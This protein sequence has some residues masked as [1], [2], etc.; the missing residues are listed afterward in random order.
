MSRSPFAFFRRRRSS[1]DELP[2]ALPDG[3]RVYAVGDIHGRLDC[4][5]LMESAIRR[6]LIARPPEGE[7]IVIFLGDY[8]DRGPDSKGVVNVLL[9]R[10]FAG[11]SVRFLMGNHEDAMLR[12]LDDPRIGASWFAYGGLATLA[13]YGVESSR[14]G[15]KGAS[16]ELSIAL[17]EKLPLEH[18]DFLAGLELFIELGGYLFV[19]AGIRP[20]KP[21]EAQRRDD[22]L[23]IREP[24]LSAK[25]LPW[26]V[27]HGH[28]VV[29]RP[30][31]GPS[32]VAL[33]TGAYATGTLTC[34]VIEGAEIEILSA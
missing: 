31:L 28:T 16:E 27:V 32:R 14:L 19:H 24:F 6:D 17:T 29:D 10:R 30:V 34:A 20:G 5:L 11:L 1:A 15:T 7:A 9:R 2:R 33:D 8:V 13:S 25:D 26:R 22:L 4:L 23:G 12:F 21:L 3:L 18:R